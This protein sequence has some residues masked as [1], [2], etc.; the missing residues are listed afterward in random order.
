MLFVRKKARAPIDPFGTNDGPNKRAPR[1]VTEILD[2]LN[3]PPHIREH[4]DVKRAE[5]A[6]KRS[7]F[8]LAV[9]NL[10][11]L[12]GVIAAGWVTY[13][14]LTVRADL[15]DPVAV[16]AAATIDAFALLAADLAVRARL[17]GEKAWTTR[18]LVYAGAA[19]SITLNLKFPFNEV[20]KFVIPAVVLAGTFAWVKGIRDRY[21]AV[22]IAIGL[23]EKEKRAQ[24]WDSIK[25]FF[26]YVFAVGLRSKK[27]KRDKEGNVVRPARVGAIAAA[28]ARAAELG[29]TERDVDHGLAMTQLDAKRQVGEFQIAD[30]VEQAIGDGAPRQLLGPFPPRKG[31]PISAPPADVVIGEGP[32]ADFLRESRDGSNAADRLMVAWIENYEQRQ[33][34]LF[35]LSW[36]V[37]NHAGALAQLLTEHGLPISD[38]T[39]RGR[40]RNLVRDGL[41]PDADA[42]KMIT[43]IVDGA[44]VATEAIT[45]G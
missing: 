45:A 27:E 1:T 3:L 25:K 15:P 34:D 24:R 17:R 21:A 22:F 4:V 2:G 20:L 33:P 23:W 30:Q 11:A 7:T 37:V 12:A 28:R 13:H 10:F 26:F 31:R 8:Y 41:Y 43:G 32:L 36:A 42:A 5:N 16:A 38:S 44:V 14:L 18:A 6:E 29:S 40:K 39:I 19:T 35:G 9:Q